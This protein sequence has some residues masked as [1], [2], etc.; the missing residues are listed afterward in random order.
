MLQIKNLTV[1]LDNNLILDKINLNI[2]EHQIL[3]IL[4]S[5][6]VGK[7]TLIKAIGGLIIADAGEIIYNNIPLDNITTNIGYTSQDYAL[8]PWYKVI[9]NITLPLIIKKL[10]VDKDT[11]DE[12][13]Q[14]LHIEN[15]LDRFPDDL[16]GGEKQRVALA[17]AMIIKPEIL[18]LDEPFSALDEVSKERARNLFLRT[19]ET[20]KPVSILVTHDIQESLLLSDNI[21]ILQGGKIKEIP[22]TVRGKKRYDPEFIALYDY[23]HSFFEKDAK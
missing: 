13:I 6:G 12:I 8:L 9:K 7:T 1:K 16:S 19:W 3:C 21:I 5:S 2:N 15:I 18:L 22:N 23:I 17:R 20:H 14:I 4:G 10:P 11:L